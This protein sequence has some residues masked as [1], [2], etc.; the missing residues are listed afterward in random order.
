MSK[1]FRVLREKRSAKAR[2]RARVLAAKY[3]AEMAL[4]ELREAR[5]MT[6]QH[7]AALLGVNQ[8][9]VSKMERRADMYVSTL[10]HM[11]RAMGGELEI[12][13]KFPEG[14]VRIGQFKKLRDEKEER[15][16]QELAAK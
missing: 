1:N 3:R 5:A 6:Q 14:V 10:R 2:E 11:I 8:A 9:A 16:T 15:D 4:H 7:L 12:V 13:A